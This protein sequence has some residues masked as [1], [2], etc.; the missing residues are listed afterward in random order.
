[1]TNILP[2]IALTITVKTKDL[3]EACFIFTD[4]ESA[5]NFAEY[6][7]KQPEVMLI[8]IDSQPTDLE[9]NCERLACWLEDYITKDESE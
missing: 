4:N 6:A 3:H 5:K 7:K 2:Q 9:S 1:M 8:T